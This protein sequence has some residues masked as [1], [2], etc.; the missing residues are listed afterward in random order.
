METNLHSVLALQHGAVLPV[1]H[2]LPENARVRDLGIDYCVLYCDRNGAAL[3]RMDETNATVT[4]S[5]AEGCACRPRS[6]LRAEAS[7]VSMSA[8]SRL[9]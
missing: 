2:R 7:S 1:F 9:P 8:P 3:Q 4:F 5:Q 6:T